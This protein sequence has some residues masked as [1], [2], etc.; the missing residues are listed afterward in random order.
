MTQQRNEMQAEFDRMKDDFSRQDELKQ[1]KLEDAMLGDLQ[2][3]QIIA[4]LKK[5]FEQIFAARSIDVSVL[6]QNTKEK[7][8]KP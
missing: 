2:K 3:D 5:Q 4:E 6:V 1:R 7:K 8:Q